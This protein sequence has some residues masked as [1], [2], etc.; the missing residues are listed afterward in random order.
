MRYY[1]NLKEVFEID[2]ITYQSFKDWLYMYTGH[3][4]PFCNDNLYR[5]ERLDLTQDGMIEYFCF[6]TD[7]KELT[8]YMV[9]NR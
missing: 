4:I 2:G 9:M 7:L 3:S 8:M 5:A 6:L 1:K